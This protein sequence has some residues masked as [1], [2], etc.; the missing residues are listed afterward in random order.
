VA[1]EKLFSGVCCASFFKERGEIF[2]P[3]LEIR[4]F[5]D[6]ATIQP[7][8]LP[9]LRTISVMAGNFSTYGGR[10]FKNLQA[11]LVAEK[12]LELI[13]HHLPESGAQ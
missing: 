4:L 6:C 9:T 13:Q 10:I 1:V 8:S 5:L 12:T 11:D 2:N 7:V 3:A